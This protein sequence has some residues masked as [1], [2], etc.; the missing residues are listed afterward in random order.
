MH[1]G[2]GV[3]LTLYTVLNCDCKCHVEEEVSMGPSQG[4]VQPPS[5]GIAVQPSSVVT[6]GQQPR[7]LCSTGIGTANSP[8]II[9]GTPPNAQGTSASFGKPASVQLLPRLSSLTPAPNAIPAQSTSAPFGKPAQ[10]LPGPSSLTGQIIIPAPNAIPTQSTVQLLPGP[11]SLTGQVMIPG[12]SNGTP[13]TTSLVVKS[14]LPQMLLFNV[15]SLLGGGAE[16]GGGV[17][18]RS[19]RGAVST[20]PKQLD[21]TAG[22]SNGQNACTRSDILTGPSAESG[23]V[24]GENST[25]N[26]AGTV[27]IEPTGGLGVASSAAGTSKEE[28]SSIGSSKA[29]KN[30]TQEVP[31]EVT[32][33]QGNEDDDDFKPSKKRL[34]RQVSKKG[35]VSN[36][37]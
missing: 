18:P 11:S 4:I 3:H 36:R 10:L 35:S 27:S 16:L 31:M 24:A 34:R 26:A 7:I 30:E 25:S 1:V 19:K 14:Q 5:Q 21:N 33:T 23:D 28:E 13:T 29:V 17:K 22:A 37:C 6:I 9:S 8:I 12:L 15:P 20:V 32:A 2:L